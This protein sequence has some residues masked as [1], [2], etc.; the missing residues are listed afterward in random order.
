[1]SKNGDPEIKRKLNIKIL[2]RF[3]KKNARK[4]AAINFILFKI[5][6]P[7]VERFKINNK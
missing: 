5:L 1:M 2:S 6:I 3:R 4:D 7:G